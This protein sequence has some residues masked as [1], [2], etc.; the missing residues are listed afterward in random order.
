MTEGSK[1]EQAA[2]QERGVVEAVTDFEPGAASGW[3]RPAKVWPVPPILGLP[4][5]APL[6]HQ[7]SDS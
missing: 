3:N 4:A 5:P 2:E 6:T 1:V 7:T